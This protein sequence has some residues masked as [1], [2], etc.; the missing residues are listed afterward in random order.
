MEDISPGALQGGLELIK[1]IEKAKR[2][3]LDEGEPSSK[4]LSRKEFQWDDIVKW[5][6]G[7]IFGLTL[8]NLSTDFFRDYSVT[9]YTPNITARDYVAYI[10]NYC[11][12]SLPRTEYFTLFII[13]HG[14]LIIGP[15]IL[16]KTAFESKYN[17][18][19][20]LVSSLDRLRE[21][22]NGEFSN[23]NFKIVT[24]LETELSNTIRIKLW[25]VFNF[26]PIYSGYLIKLVLQ[27]LT[28][29]GS[30]VFSLC[31][32]V[33]FSEMFVCPTAAQEEDIINDPKKWPIA[34]TV[35][36]VYPSLRFLSLLRYGDLI[37]L[38]AIILSLVYGLLWTLLRHPTELGSKRVAEFSSQSNLHHDLYRPSQFWRDPFTP[39]IE[40]DIDFLLLSLFQASSGQGVTFKQLQISQ[41]MTKHYNKS[42]ELLQ[43][44]VN[45]KSQ[46]FRANRKRLQERAE[47]RAAAERER[48]EGTET[49]VQLVEVAEESDVDR[50]SQAT[51]LFRQA[52]FKWP[53]KIDFHG[54]PRFE[55]E[56]EHNKRFGL[57]EEQEK[58]PSKAEIKAIATKLHQERES[59]T[60]FFEALFQRTGVESTVSSP[61][62][63]QV[64]FA[65]ECGPQRYGLLTE[66]V[67][68][69][70]WTE[71][72]T[73]WSNQ[74]G[75]IRI[76]AKVLMDKENKDLASRLLSG[77]LGNR[78]EDIKK[79][80]SFQNRLYGFLQ[81]VKS[82]KK[83]GREYRRLAIDI[84][85]DGFGCSFILAWSFETVCVL[86]FHSHYRNNKKQV[87]E[88]KLLNQV[89]IIT[90]PIDYYSLPANEADNFDVALEDI[91]FMC[92]PENAEE[93]AA[94]RSGE[95][96]Q[97]D[98]CILWN[99]S[100]KNLEKSPKGSVLHLTLQR[101]VLC[102]QL[103]LRL[104]INGVDVRS[105]C[106]RYIPP[107]DLF[108]PIEDEEGPIA[109]EQQSS[110]RTILDLRKAIGEASF[111][112]VGDDEGL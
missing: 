15:H 45:H 61:T 14:F 63:E 85:F 66:E 64:T 39:R 54:A 77:E 37:L 53:V 95:G 31:Y 82:H 70:Q 75:S 88:D 11:Y 16:W 84:S 27:L 36:C 33:D 21:S 51:E 56:T 9:C 105:Q 58:P 19:F 73:D 78:K 35:T 89:N 29:S 100:R 5:L 46:M 79:D 90:V 48:S 18:F 44:I 107:K 94:R 108:E 112:K 8:L 71:T 41:E 86:N 110:I 6:V 22:S 40:S 25:R 38:S 50:A 17:F 93:R 76:L 52:G 99:Q 2:G 92:H 30:V 24:R 34:E 28:A 62:A 13:V 87:I 69:S 42:S 80:K 109:E 57:A 12:S 81:L 3:D 103:G 32:F 7:G 74:R 47:Q 65:P 111:I 83:G 98:Q 72:L 97:S 55:V 102:W 106:L 96:D 104:L 43:L 20:D 26:P 59:Y 91:F 23:K 67:T 1:K 68:L 101:S 49:E 10:N 60:D 4:L